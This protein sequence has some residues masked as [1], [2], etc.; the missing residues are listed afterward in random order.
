LIVTGVFGLSFVNIAIGVIG[1][2]AALAC[3][4]TVTA[5]R[6]K[7]PSRSVIARMPSR[8]CWSSSS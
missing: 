2:L 7:R 3:N 6:R 5:W 1:L 8:A 4:V